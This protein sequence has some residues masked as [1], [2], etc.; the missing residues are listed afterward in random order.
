VSLVNRHGLS[1][2]LLVY[3]PRRRN[4]H[5]HM[6][7][8]GRQC[9]HAPGG[10]VGGLDSSAGCVF[11]GQQVEKLIGGHGAEFG[12]VPVG[13]EADGYVLVGQLPDR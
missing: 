10:L 4:G 5:G 7:L 9:R 2:V 3:G 11:A 8:A 6:L 12:G 13:D 1:R